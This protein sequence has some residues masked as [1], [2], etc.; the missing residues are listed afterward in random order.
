M[1]IGVR[2]GGG[3]GRWLLE[4]LE[5]VAPEGAVHGRLGDLSGVLG[6]HLAVGV[7]LLLL[8]LELLLELDTASL[9]SVG[10]LALAL[11]GHVGGLAIALDPLDAA[12]LFLIG[13]F[14][15]LARR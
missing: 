4:C 14:G 11:A 8:G 13:G 1:D 15:T 7:Q 5:R 10:L 6:E 9:E 3:L 2:D 12:L